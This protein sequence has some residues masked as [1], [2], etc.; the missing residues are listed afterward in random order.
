MQNTR[1]NDLDG[2]TLIELLVV[3]LI[4]GILAS[5]ALPQYN[6]AVERSKSAEALTLLKSVGQ[7]YEAYY[8]ASGNYAVSFD[9]LSLDIP[10]SGNEIFLP[11]SSGGQE[12]K[13]NNDWIL[14]IQTNAT[15]GSS[16]L[17]YMVRKSGKYKGAGFFMPWKLTTGEGTRE[18]SCFE[19]LPRGGVT[20][21]FD[22]SLPAGAY[23]EKIMHGTLKNST[24]YNRS[25]SL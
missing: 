6:K 10:W 14:Q 20:V 3:V 9:E 24:V 13:S 11:S 19:R 8:L 18:I 1:L 17:L 15:A 22:T 12:S 2:F 7:A 4:I 23:C 21:Y 5:V 25:Y 16:V